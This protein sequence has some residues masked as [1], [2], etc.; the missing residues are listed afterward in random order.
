MSGV[1]VDLVFNR[2]DN[3]LL[4]CEMKYRQRPLGKSV[5]KEIQHKMAVLGE[6]FPTKTVQ[7]VLV[8]H[9][10]V[11]DELLRAPQIFKTLDA[12]VLLS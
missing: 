6:L 2:A 8:Y 4:L 1:Q 12:S 3:V 9:G 11:T 10:D 7:S 5:A